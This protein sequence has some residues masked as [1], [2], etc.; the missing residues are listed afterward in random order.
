M[1]GKW[2]CKN[3]MDQLH[4]SASWAA[5]MWACVDCGEGPCLARGLP[6][7]GRLALPSLS[8]QHPFSPSLAFNKLTSVHRAC[9]RCVDSVSVNLMAA[10][11]LT[12]SH[13][14]LVEG[15][16]GLSDLP[17]HRNWLTF[18]V[19]A[20]HPHCLWG[21]SLSAGLPLEPWGPRLTLPRK[22]C[23]SRCGFFSSW[24]PTCCH[25]L[26]RQDMPGGR[27]WQEVRGHS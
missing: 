6:P 27:R 21:R 10:S 4:T 13:R 11:I 15:L 19:M 8:C 9:F 12:L 14:H 18:P 1:V 2:L 5:R 16:L 26:E 20:L 7:L 3:S 25:C 22:T 23:S 24:D 17:A